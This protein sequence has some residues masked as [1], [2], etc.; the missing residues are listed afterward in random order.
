V[1]P[2]RWK[3][4]SAA[5]YAKVHDATL[6]VGRLEERDSGGLAQVSLS[7]QTI[8]ASVGLSRL[9][10]PSPNGSTISFQ[11][12]GAGVRVLG[13][14]LRNR[15]AV[16]RWLATRLRGTPESAVTVIAAG[17]RWPD[18]SLRPA[19]E[20][21]WGVGAVIA[22]LRDQGITG[23]SPEAAMAA[24]AF[25]AVASDLTT[26]LMTCSSGRELC[27]ARFDGDVVVAAELDTSGCVPLLVDGRFVDAAGDAG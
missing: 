18:G 5:E 2:Y 1:Y 11:L 8:R 19:V 10:L 7:P 27:D 6:A 24:A 22:S 12:D 17:E 25:D 20:D 15:R 4:G 3:D 23:L 14:S 21:L 13:A 26:S 9:V 16:A